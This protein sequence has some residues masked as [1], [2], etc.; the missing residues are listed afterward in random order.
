MFSCLWHYIQCHCGI[1]SYFDYVIHYY[2]DTAYS[3]ISYK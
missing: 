2:L 3:G 1:D